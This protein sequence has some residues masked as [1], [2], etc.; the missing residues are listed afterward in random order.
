MSAQH[1]G[2]ADALILPSPLPR[3]PRAKLFPNTRFLRLR[4][5]GLG[6]CQRIMYLDCHN[7]CADSRIEAGVLVYEDIA[8]SDHAQHTPEYWCIDDAC[9][10]E[11]HNALSRLFG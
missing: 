1:V 4:C 2:R 10:G 3:R 9:L 6:K 8:E 11:Q 5:H 7:G